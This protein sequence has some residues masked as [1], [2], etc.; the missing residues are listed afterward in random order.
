VNKVSRAVR[1]SFSQNGYMRLTDARL[2]Y[3]DD[4]E[5]R[6]TKNNQPMGFRS[7]AEGGYK[8]Y[9]PPVNEDGVWY[10]IKGQKCHGEVVYE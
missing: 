2:R 3:E 9:L 8:Q 7:W 6:T 10:N 1:D 5:N 4:F